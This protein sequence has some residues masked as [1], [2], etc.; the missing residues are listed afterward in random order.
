MSNKRGPRVE[1]SVNKSRRRVV[2]GA[3]GATTL[4][5]TGAAPYIVLARESDT[6][7]VNGY[8]GEFQPL[9]IDN[10]IKP[11]EKK[12]GVKVIYDGTGTAS[13]AVDGDDRVSGAGPAASGVA[14]EGD[15]AV[16]SV[17]DEDEGGRE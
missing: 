11:F 2:K 12:M 17:D 3:I 7:V 5:V 15:D 10:V 9:Y 4:A 13:G 14:V 1:H 6:L 16:P 8:G